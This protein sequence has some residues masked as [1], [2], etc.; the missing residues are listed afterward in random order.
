MREGTVTLNIVDFQAA[1]TPL[2]PEDVGYPYD[3]LDLSR[4]VPPPGAST[5]PSSWRTRSSKSPCCPTWARI[6]QIRDK[7]R[8]QPLLSQQP[9]NRA[10][11]L[12]MRGWWLAI[13]GIEW[14]L[15]TEEHG[16]AEYLPWNAT[17]ESAEGEAAVTVSF[18]ERLTGVQCQVR[19]SLDATHS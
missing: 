15:P 16:L 14:A 5:V 11:Q 4:S 18:E 17:T 19:I 8:G 3:A 10:D 7:V 6:Y 12:G 2:R 13:G 1:L 9:C